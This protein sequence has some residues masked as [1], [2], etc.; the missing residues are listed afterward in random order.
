M[1][2]KS[3]GT[4]NSQNNFPTSPGLSQ[5]AWGDVTVDQLLAHQSGIPANAPWGL[6]QRKNKDVR[7]GRRGVLEWLV[8]TKRPEKVEFLYSNVNYCLAG[9]LLETHYDQPWET[10]IEERLFKPLHMQSAGFGVPTGPTENSVPWGHRELLGVRH[11]VKIDNAPVLG[12]A[13]TV[14]ATLADWAK[15]LRVHLSPPSTQSHGLPLSDASW[16]HLHDRTVSPGYFAGWFHLERPWASGPV[17]YHNG[18]NTYWFC[19]TFLAEKKGYGIFAATN[20]GTEQAILACDEAVKLFIRP[21]PTK[22]KP[23]SK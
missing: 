22:T 10:I 21:N 14:H 4:A 15:F 8:T 20:L 1:K 12:P 16:K 19:A 13:G 9:L 5:S 11:A 17:L 3:L 18:T 7:E 2:E 6:I 23:T